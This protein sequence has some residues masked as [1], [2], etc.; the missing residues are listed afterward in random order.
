MRYN[1]TKIQIFFKCI[2]CCVFL[3]VGFTYSKTMQFTFQKEFST[4]LQ[5]SSKPSDSN[6]EV[7][8]GYAKYKLALFVATQKD[9]D[10]LK[11]NQVALRPLIESIVAQNNAN[12]LQASNDRKRVEQEISKRLNEYLPKEFP[13]DVVTTPFVRATYIVNMVIIPD[14]DI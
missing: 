5:P 3:C 9:I 11:K 14:Y 13:K 10:F 1:A 7:V 2:V 8:G 6:M 12:D 4:K